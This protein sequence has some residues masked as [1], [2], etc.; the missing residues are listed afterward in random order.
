MRSAA[1]RA[2]GQRNAQP[3]LPAIRERFADVEEAGG[4][5]AS[6]AQALAQL[7]DRGSL[8]AFTLAARDLLGARPSS[9]AALVGTASIAA[10]GRLHPADLQQRLE[11]LVRVSN[12][13]AL[14]A[15]VLAALETTERCPLASAGRPAQ[16]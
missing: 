2:L 9:D 3:F 6:A 16:R 13:P 1:L 5:R 8:D 15:L 4:V 11:P 7:C 12:Q 10:L 14:R